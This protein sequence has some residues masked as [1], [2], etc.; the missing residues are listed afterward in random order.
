MGEKVLF[1]MRVSQDDDGTHVEINASPEWREAHGE[2]SA[3]GEHDARH[4]HRF[5]AWMGCCG[6]AHHGP[7]ESRRP[8]A[9]DLRRA[10]DSLQHI[11]DDL[12]GSS[13]EAAS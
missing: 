2:R 5:A 9:D 3:H 1:E 8:A 11:Y 7:H 6:D 4:H 12:Y 13:V 10:L